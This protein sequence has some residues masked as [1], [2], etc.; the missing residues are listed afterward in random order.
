MPAPLPRRA[1]I[2]RAATL[3]R[4]ALSLRRLPE[5]IDVEHRI[6]HRILQ[7]AA[8]LIDATD[9]G[10]DDGVLSVVESERAARRLEANFSE[11][12]EEARLVLDVAVHG[13]ERLAARLRGQIAE[14]IVV[15]GIFPVLL[16]EDLDEALVLRGVQ[17]RR[18]REPAHDA[19][20]GI[21]D[22]AKVCLVHQLTQAEQRKLSLEAIF[23]P[24]LHPLGRARPP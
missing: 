18:V 14:V 3:S 6:D 11:R 7:L 8:D 13:S 2:T 21:A 1:S 5:L 23:V 20:R 22:L 9:I 10:G 24:R 15:D 12:F 4:C 17:R 19:E 16:L